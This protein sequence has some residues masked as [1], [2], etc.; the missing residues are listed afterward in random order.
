MY[1]TKIV[2]RRTPL[3]KHFLV[4][5]LLDGKAAGSLGVGGFPKRDAGRKSQVR[6]VASRCL[7]NNEN[8]LVLRALR[9][10]HPWGLYLRP[11]FRES[12]VVTTRLSPLRPALRP[13]PPALR[14]GSCIE[15]LHSRVMNAGSKLS[16]GSSNTPP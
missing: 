16:E 10:Q 15:D 13:L 5:A 6:R 8:S 12:A 4:D 11:G 9:R 2:G 14:G 7:P 3:S 1:S